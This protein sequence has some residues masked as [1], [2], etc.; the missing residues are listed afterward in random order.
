[1][2]TCLATGCNQPTADNTDDYTAPTAKLLCET[3]MP[4]RDRGTRTRFPGNRCW[5]NAITCPNPPTTQYVGGR[6]CDQHSP[7]NSK[8]TYGT[9]TKAKPQF[10]KNNE[11]ADKTTRRIEYTN[12]DNNADD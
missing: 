5:G 1:M 9:T 3:H 10:V 6:Y 11:Q 2:A 7:P 4:L 12:R 8:G